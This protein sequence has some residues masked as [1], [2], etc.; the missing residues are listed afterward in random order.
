MTFIKEKEISIHLI[1]RGKYN[2]KIPGN[3]QTLD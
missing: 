3:H 1:V 2:L